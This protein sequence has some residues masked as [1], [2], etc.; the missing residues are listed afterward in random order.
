[1]LRPGSD[2]DVVSISKAG[3]TSRIIGLPAHVT[4]HGARH[5]E[6]DES[7]DGEDQRRRQPVEPRGTHRRAPRDRRVTRVRKGRERT[8]DVVRRESVA[9]EQRAQ[10]PSRG[11]REEKSESSGDDK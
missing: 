10:Q 1:M 6:G 11:Q 3:K 7:G 5:E 2:N 8:R 9:R 4:S